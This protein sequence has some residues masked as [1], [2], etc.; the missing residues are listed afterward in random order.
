MSTAMPPL[1]RLRYAEAAEAYLRSLPLEHFMEAV[2]Q[3]TQ[4]KITV[5]SMDLVRVHRPDVQTF[6][7]LLI[8]FPLGGWQTIR[9]VV[10]DNFSVV[11]DEPIR[12]DTSYDVPFQPVRPYLVMEYVS[13][14]SKRKDYEDNHRI[15]ERELKVPYYLVF[16]P[17][18]QELT[19]FHLRGRRYVTVKPG[20]NGRLA[21]PELELEVAIHEGWMRFWFR[22]ELLPLPAELQRELDD[23]RRRL[24]EESRRADEQTRRAEEEALRAD[25]QARRAEAEALRADEQARRAEDLQQQVQ[26]EREAR[27]AA[28]RELAELRA[29]LA[30]RPR[31][32][33][34]PR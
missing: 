9:Q 33:N 20:R 1:L 29:R 15:Y 17:D 4:R 11:H 25:E 5:V 26:A 10:P 6:N 34:G 31:G 22:G 2:S 23:T 28:E 13:K 32:K 14:S 12:A 19:L 16:Y 21:I 7:E 3:A 8:Q 24:A 18:N 27:Q 30:E